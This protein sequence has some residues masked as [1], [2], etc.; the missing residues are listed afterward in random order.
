MN[1]DVRERWGVD[2]WRRPT[3]GAF[4]RPYAAQTFLIPKVPTLRAERR[5][6]GQCAPARPLRS[7]RGAGG[8]LGAALERSLYSGGGEVPAPGAEGT[9][10]QRAVPLFAA[11]SG[12]LSLACGPQPLTC[13]PRRLRPC[14]E[15]SSRSLQRAPGTQ[16]ESE[17]LPAPA[18]RG[19]ASSRPLAARVG[20]ALLIGGPFPSPDTGGAQAPRRSH[21]SLL[22]TGKSE[23]RPRPGSAPPAPDSESPAP[24][25]FLLLRF[26]LGARCA[27]QQD[28]CPPA[29]P[30]NIR[31]HGS[32][33]FV[34]SPA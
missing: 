19:P 26:N 16:R 29:N 27:L 7:P 1:S 24:G 34:S 18:R 8:P 10:A 12:A 20:R 15:R 21:R 13:P 17:R 28:S 11:T 3:D 2:H 9:E 5:Q 30:A 25:F 22:Q 31:L 6:P 4:R 14:S 33:Q 23:P 32:F